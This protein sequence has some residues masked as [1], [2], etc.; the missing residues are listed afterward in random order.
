MTW[1]SA[2]DIF[3][4]S[5]SSW[6]FRAGLNSWQLD[7]FEYQVMPQN[8]LGQHDL[9][10]YIMWFLWTAASGHAVCAIASHELLHYSSF[11]CMLTSFDPSPSLHFILAPPCLLFFFFHGHS[12]ER[13]A[14]FYIWFKKKNDSRELLFIWGICSLGGMD[15]ILCKDKAVRCWL[16]KRNQFKCFHFQRCGLLYL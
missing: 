7:L 4:Q 8:H 14:G 13:V 15:W 16:F 1:T 3:M 10:L 6:V 9:M 5:W 2:E 11:N 12:V